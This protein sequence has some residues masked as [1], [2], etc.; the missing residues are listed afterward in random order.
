MTKIPIE[1]RTVIEEVCARHQQSTGLADKLTKYFE[2]LVR[3]NTQEED[4]QRLIETVWVSGGN[5]N[6]TAN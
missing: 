3:E 6:E 4:L 1:V 5:E 2:N